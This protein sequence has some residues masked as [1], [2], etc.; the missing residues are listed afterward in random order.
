MDTAFEP[1][2]MPFLEQALGGKFQVVV[3]AIASREVAYAP[4]AVQELFQSFA[5]LAEIIETTE[6]ALR[7]RSAYVH[8]G[9]VLRKSLNDALHVALATVSDCDM[10]VSWNFRDIVNYRKIPLYN[11]VNVVNG[12]RAVSIHSPLEVIEDEED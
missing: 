8:A 10:I 3:S 11:A 6:E 7:L 9:F 12:Y 1:A 5:D 2:S 4:R